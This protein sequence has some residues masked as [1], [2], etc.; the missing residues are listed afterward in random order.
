M[1]FPG[2]DT[3]MGCRFLLHCSLCYDDVFQLGP[4]GCKDTSTGLWGAG[5][6]TQTGLELQGLK[7]LG[8]TI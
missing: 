8:V 4:Q 5:K 6:Q 3:G 7:Q 2:K 1:R